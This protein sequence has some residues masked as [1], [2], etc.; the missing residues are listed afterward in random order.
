MQHGDA[1]ALPK[2]THSFLADDLL[3]GFMQAQLLHLA[4]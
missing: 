3:K 1:I 4:G 2:G